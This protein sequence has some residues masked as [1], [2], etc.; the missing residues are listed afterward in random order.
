MKEYNRH[1]GVVAFNRSGKAFERQPFEY[2]FTERRKVYPFWEDAR[3]IKGYYIEKLKEY[4]INEIV[5]YIC[6]II[7]YADLKKNVSILSGIIDLRFSTQLKFHLI[8]RGLWNDVNKGIKLKKIPEEYEKFIRRIIEN[9]DDRISW[10]IAQYHLLYM[11]GVCKKGDFYCYMSSH[12]IINDR[13]FR[14]ELFFGKTSYGPNRPKNATHIEEDKIRLMK[15]GNTFFN[16]YFK[17]KHDFNE[18]YFNGLQ[19]NIID[20]ARPNLLSETQILIKILYNFHYILKE[21]VIFMDHMDKTARYDGQK[22]PD[23]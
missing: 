4:Q 6:K 14:H 20:Y 21:M 8:G 10:T 17:Y 15:I 12:Q 18:R 13:R 9:D 5:K 16:S 11:R 2:F 1:Y 3:K 19:F 23:S 7:C 22:T